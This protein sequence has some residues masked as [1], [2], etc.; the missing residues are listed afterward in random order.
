[1]STSVRRTHGARY[2]RKRASAGITITS[3]LIYFKDIIVATIMFIKAYL[4]AF[5]LTGSAAADHTRRAKKGMGTGMGEGR[6]TSSQK[7]QIMMTVQVLT[8]K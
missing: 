8:E 4:L 7:N 1:M 5:L 3:S 2:E 6:A